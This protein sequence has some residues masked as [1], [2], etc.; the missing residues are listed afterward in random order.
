[1]KR[2]RV[3]RGGGSGKT[4]MNLT[5]IRID[6]VICA[7]AS[8][9]LHVV[10]ALLDAGFLQDAVN[11]HDAD[12]GPCRVM[13]AIARIDQTCEHGYTPATCIFS[14]CVCAQS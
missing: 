9:A 13:T 2:G 8:D 5:K 14:D 11:D 1:V 7:T 6:L 3:K 10:D 4:P 12:A